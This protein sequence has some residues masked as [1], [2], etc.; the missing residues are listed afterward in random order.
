A[1]PAIQ[2][3]VT[4]NGAKVLFY[5]APELP[6][7]DIRATFAAGSM[8]D[9]KLGG[10]ARLTNGLLA[11]G[12][13]GL[14]AQA[15]AER[16]ERAG[17]RFSNGSL[18]EMAWI[19]LRSLTEPANQGPALRTFVQVLTLPD[20]NPAAVE[21]VRK[22]MLS[23][24]D[25]LEQSPS[26]VAERAFYRALYADHPYGNTPEG[27][28]DSL[29]A[30][31]GADLR[32][33]YERYYVARNLT[34]VMVGDVDRKQAERIAQ[35]IAV[36]LPAGKKAPDLP[37]PPALTDA[38]TVHV[39]FPSRQSHILMGTIGMQR[40]DPEYFDLY[41]ANHVFG[42]SGFASR[43]L[44][45]IRERNGLAYS[46]SSYFLPMAER[47]PF[48]L[49]VQTRGEQAAKAIELAQRELQQYVANGASAE[50]LEA[51]QRNITGGFA[52]RIDSN[53]KLLQYL[54]T[55]GYYDLPMDYLDSFN[56][57]IEAV[58]VESMRAALRERIDP[59]KLITVIVGQMSG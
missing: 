42:G 51:S 45:T 36:G 28:R 7:L 50:E 33:F 20:F 43:L 14:D 57:R 12:A 41:V 56:T 37:P 40:G 3:W 13:A 59:E 21:R 23:A 4:D 55:I 30:I 54:T 47:G 6:M 34:L 18:R 48:M 19:A 32:A 2:T 53:R 1:G 24:L 22:Q 26:D 11:E 38:R 46:A 52:L 49:G 9:A 35:T 58:S 44:T 31:S 27:D 29:T 10:V 39:D 5:P 25:Q 8:R 15:I 17:A 16:F